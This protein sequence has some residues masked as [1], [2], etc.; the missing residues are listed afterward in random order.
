[1]IRNITRD[2]N[3]E[4]SW[5]VVDE[6]IATG[7]TKVICPYC[8]VKPEFNLTYSPLTKQ[9]ERIVGGCKCGYIRHCVV[10]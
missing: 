4:L 5:A 6:I 10:S 3:S 9:I 1:M 2:C 8:N 7:D